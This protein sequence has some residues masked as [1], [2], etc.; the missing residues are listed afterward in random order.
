MADKQTVV[1]AF[2]GGLD[3]SYCVLAL[4]QQGFE[5]H[6]AFVDTGGISAEQKRWI[7]DRADA[8]G[9]AKHHE[10]DASEPL[11]DQFVVPLL[12]SGARMLEQYPML[13]SDR[14]V[15]VE[16]CL[17]LADELGTTHFAHGCTGMGNDQ[18]RFDQSVRSL[19]DYV[20]HAPIR[21]LQRET[22]NVRAHELE[23][24]AA[25]GIEVPES[26]SRYSI[27]E[28]LLGV[29]LSGQE[30][31]EFGKPGDDTH[32]WCRPR[33]DWPEA[34]LEL[35]IGF[36]AGRAVSLNDRPM[37]GP[38]LLAEL[39]RQL[40]AYGVGRHIYT[41]DVSI[42]LK[43]RIVFECPGV[44][45]LMIAQ[46]ALR[47]AVNTRLQNQFHQTIAQR[48]AELVYTGFFFEPHKYDLEAY[49][50]SANRYVTGVVRLATH[51]GSATAV[52]VGSRYLLKDPNSVYAQSAGWTP[53][54]AE[55]FV[56]LIGQS[57]TLAARVRKPAS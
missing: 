14:Y 44:D 52:S 50:E 23:L 57:S 54:E 24:M 22:R 32:V 36:E 21:D 13:C 16:Q 51:G 7:A 33:A 53:E 29:T 49:L 38:A 4:K 11:W 25:A 55:G 37:Q 28:N 30:I 6:T 10:L 41:G 43:G 34:P 2:S 19:G 42:G 17:R 45:G 15:I 48:W 5:V 3:T 8:L 9:A 47:E 35:T 56:K 27:N 26:S 20:I 12:W 18:L 1:L 31:D 39:N 40:G 46:R